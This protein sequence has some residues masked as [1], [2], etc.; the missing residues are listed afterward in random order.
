MGGGEGETS[1]KSPKPLAG[2]EQ[3]PATSSA[4]AV[5]V[6]PD[7]SN[8]QACPPIPPHGLFPVPSSPQAYPYMWGAPHLMPPFG[9]PPPPYLMYPPRGL[10]SHPSV[11]PGLHPFGPYAMST[12]NMNAENSGVVP[13]SMEM[14]GKSCKGKEKG[15]TKRSK[16]GCSSSN[17]TSDKNNSETRKS[18]G[19]PANEVPQRCIIPGNSTSDSS[20]EESDD[21]SQNDSQPKTSGGGESFDDQAL[22]QAMMSHTRA[23]MPTPAAAGPG[24]VVGPATNL[25]IGMEYWAAS[26]LSHIPSMHGKMPTTAVGGAVAPSGPSEHWLQDERERKRQRRKQSNREAARRSRMRKQAEFEELANR[27]ETLKEENTSLRTELNRIKSEYEHLL[28][29]NNSLKEK[30]GE[31]Q[32]E[33]QEPGF[34]RN[35][36]PLGKENPK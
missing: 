25:N 28:S 34:E 8:F 19:P 14:D 22:S 33:T 20:S 36:Q 15:P 30:L 24:G 5:P 10:Y 2:Q 35:D 32:K 3:S 17:M 18:S 16:G 4:A 29:E 13:S 26:S 21:T 27:A 7:W 6:Y 12:T 9:A 23:V 1:T 11:P 31:V